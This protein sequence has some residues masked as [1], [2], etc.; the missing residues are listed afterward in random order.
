MAR[1]EVQTHTMCDGW[2]NCWSETDEDNVDTL[3]TFSTRDEAEAAIHEFFAD[4][5]RAGIGQQYDM[6]EYRVVRIA[7][8]V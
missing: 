6:E 5:Y 1:Y 4:L 8:A 2:I 7:D 3:Q